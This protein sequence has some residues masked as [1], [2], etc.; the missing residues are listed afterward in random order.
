[1][2]IEKWKDSCHRLI[3]E[4]KP[5]SFKQRVDHI[6]TYYKESMLLVALAIVVVIAAISSAINANRQIMVSGMLCNVGMSM[7]GYNYLTEDFF[8]KYDGDSRVEDAFLSSQEF[9]LP[10]QM[11]TN[12]ID[13]SYVSAMSVLSLVESKQLDYVIITEDAFGYFLGHEIFLDLS[14]F[15]TPAEMEQWKGLVV[16]GQANLEDGT[17]GEVYPAAINITELP[18]TKDCIRADEGETVY[19]TII[20]NTPRMEQCRQIWADIQAWESDDAA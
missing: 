8:A 14:E 11:D 10:E 6:W 1:M 18:F 15:L 9:A 20:V 4:M 12:Q 16:Y 3:E 5:M 7:E 17:K 19:L 2:S 13:T